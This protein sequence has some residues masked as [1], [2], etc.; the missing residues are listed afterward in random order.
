[1]STSSLQPSSGCSDAAVHCYSVCV[2]V[3]VWHVSASDLR[4]AARRIEESI[5][6]PSAVLTH[7]CDR[8]S[9]GASALLPAIPMNS[10]FLLPSPYS[11]SDSDTPATQ[12]HHGVRMCVCVYTGHS[13]MRLCCYDAES[14]CCLETLAGICNTSW[15]VKPK[16]SSCNLEYI[17][18]RPTL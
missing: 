1:M 18:T 13:N 9:A 17:R 3:C 16:D 5:R 6:F 2:C 12:K 15:D 14:T 4:V 10:H 11:G 8:L 7:L